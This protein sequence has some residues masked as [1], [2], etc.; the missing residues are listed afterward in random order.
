MVQESS[1]GTCGSPG[2]IPRPHKGEGQASVGR[3]E[4]APPHSSSECILT[5]RI[6]IQ[7]HSTLHALILPCSKLISLL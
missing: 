7:E 6:Q 3:G 1:T 4:K 2:G 5:A